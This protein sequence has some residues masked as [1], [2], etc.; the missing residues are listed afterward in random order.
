MATETITGRLLL[1]RYPAA[2]LEAAN[3]ILLAGEVV[4]IEDGRYKCGP[5]RWNA[6]PIRGRGADL[7]QIETMLKGKA[8]TDLANV[9]LV[10]NLTALTINFYKAPDGLMLAWGLQAGAA[11]GNHTIYFPMAFAAVPL[12]VFCFPAGASIP[13]ANGM[14]YCY[15]S[16]K[17]INNFAVS[18]RKNSGTSIAYSDTPFF[19]LALGRWK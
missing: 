5:G 18:V 3:P 14:V 17:T 4:F 2:D 11:N 6:L 13:V 15:C 1:P 10:K 16:S 19:W 12:A 8:D 7:A 9:T